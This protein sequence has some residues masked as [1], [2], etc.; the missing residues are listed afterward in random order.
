MLPLG[1]GHPC[2]L[3]P[4][5]FL[6]KILHVFVI[7]LVCAT[8]HAY[9][10]LLDRFGN[11]RRITIECNTILLLSFGNLTWAK[12][13]N[14]T[15]QLQNNSHNILW[16]DCVNIFFRLGVVDLEQLRTFL[17]CRRVSFRTSHI[18]L[19]VKQYTGPELIDL[20][21]MGSLHDSHNTEQ[22]NSVISTSFFYRGPHFTMVF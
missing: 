11:T 14:S 16:W 17:N 7:S 22:I 9:L 8:C 2:F 10:I 21:R 19:L 4:S 13:V 20:T 3:F 6:T 12:C 18:N 5:Y 1:L 15:L